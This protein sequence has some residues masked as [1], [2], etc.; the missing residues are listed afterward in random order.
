MAQHISDSD[1][2][3]PFQWCFYTFPKSRNVSKEDV[4][5]LMTFQPFDFYCVAAETH[6]D[7][8]PHIHALIHYEKPITKS[9][10]KKHVIKQY[11]DDWKRQ[12]FGRIRKNSSAWH[13]HQY[14]LKEDPLPITYGPSPQR[15]NAQRDRVHNYVARLG[16]DSIDRFDRALSERRA[17][18]AEIDS[19]ILQC[20]RN[21]EEYNA[22]YP[23]ELPLFARDIIR[24]FVEP[25]DFNL[26]LSF[27]LFNSGLSLNDETSMYNVQKF[28]S[29]FFYP[30]FIL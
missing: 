4:V 25:S 16:Y 26:D 15:S 19:Q 27:T 11:P 28:I 23:L 1:G 29:L 6:E 5:K 17:S 10:I 30:T 12:Q 2:R 20:I 21:I 13:A 14:I 18:Y 7:G 24:L 3:H 8:S 22:Y 9:K